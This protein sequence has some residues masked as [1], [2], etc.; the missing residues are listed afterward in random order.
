MFA[1]SVVALVPVVLVFLVFQRR[2]LAGMAHSGL[3]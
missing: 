2:I 1:M 3:K